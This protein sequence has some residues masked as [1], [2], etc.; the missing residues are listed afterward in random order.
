LTTKKRPESTAEIVRFLYASFP[1]WNAKQIY[2]LYCIFVGGSQNAVTLNAIQKQLEHIKEEYSQM[3]LAGLDEPWSIGAGDF[4]PSDIIP[5]LLKIQR[6]I[7]LIKRIEPQQILTIRHAL[8][9]A[10]LF[11]SVRELVQ[12][13]PRKAYNSFLYSILIMLNLFLP[14]IK[15]SLDE[16]SKALLSTFAS[17][18]KK[19]PAPNSEEIVML[20]IVWLVVIGVQYVRA[21]QVSIISGNKKF[22][23]SELDDLFFVQGSLDEE[24]FLDGLWTISMAA[25]KTNAFSNYADYS[26]EQ[27]EASFGKLNT[28][29][30]ASLN[31]YLRAIFYG[32]LFRRKWI[33]DNLEKYAKINEILEA[34]R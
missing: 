2:D 18:V 20:Q 14:E 33:A 23:S 7:K 29:Q 19:Q 4:I 11:P 24:T 3:I 17:E 25:Y 5:T 26:K 9:Y 30:V 22:Q 34:K 21:E 15:D 10:R 31:E 13:N 32:P 6:F 16:S 27:L 1:R 28:E 12:S 8:W